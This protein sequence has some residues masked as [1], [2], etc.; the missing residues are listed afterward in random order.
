MINKKNWL[1]MLLMVLALVMTTVESLYAQTD[2]RLNGRWVADEEYTTFEYKFNNGNYEAFEDKLPSDKG[3]YIINNGNIIF[4]VT[5][6]HGDYL[7]MLFNF[8]NVNIKFESKW[9]TYNE[10]IITIRSNL[11]KMGYSDSFIDSV[12]KSMI[13]LNL[14]FPYS[15]D[16]NT[17]ILNIDDYIL[18]L[19]KE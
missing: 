9:Y 4:T 19:N 12:V 11:R 2:N 16:N 17:L 13:S 3:T 14:T 8:M 18:I 1:V 15:V 5:H 6:V 7:N 10:H